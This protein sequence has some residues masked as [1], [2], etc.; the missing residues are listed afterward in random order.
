M[1]RQASG[2]TLVELAVVL[3]IL[4]L[5]VAG[6]LHV[7]TLST[8]E[9]NRQVTL[10]RLD[11]IEEALLAF[12]R[13]HGRLPCPASATVNGGNGAVGVELGTPGDGNCSG[14][15]VLS[16]GG[17][18]GR[19]GVVPTRALQLP[20]HYMFDGWGQ[21]ITYAVDR[22]ITATGAFTTYP[23]TDTTTIGDL[24][25]MAPGS[26]QRTARAVVVVLSH[27]EN[28]HG[29]YRYNGA[30][31]VS[32]SINTSE[33][34]NC[35]CNSSGTDASVDNQYVMDVRAHYSSNVANAF[36]DIV[37]YKMRWQ[38][39]SGSSGPQTPPDPF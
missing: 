1:A 24:V 6:G 13:A 25:V 26:V 14:A 19:E 2:F 34:D 7:A 37:R 38:L 11:A 33:Q 5:L 29:G 8:K 21:R 31:K 39:F 18:N 9:R 27:G 17:G 30:R 16:G 22:R 32:G 3:V 12:R 10:T 28:G 36:D 20:D 4:S 15:T 23:I 35:H